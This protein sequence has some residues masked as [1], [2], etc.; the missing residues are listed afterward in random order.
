MSK[1]SGQKLKILYLLKFFKEK[2]DEEHGVTMSEI[3]AYLNSCG[4]TAERKS[5]YAD[6]EALNIFGADIAF[7]GRRYSLASRDFE[8]AELKLLADCVGASKFI[9]EKK[10]TELIKK[11]ENLASVYEAAEIR[12][13]VYI[14]DRVKA[15]NE[16][17]YYVIDTLHDAI[18]AGKKIRFMYYEYD[19]SKHRKAKHGGEPYVVS[20]Y[21][22]TVSDENY[23][24]IAHYPKYEKLTHFRVDRMEGVEI[25]DEQRTDI[26]TVAGDKFSLGEYSRSTFNMFKG[27]LETVKLR[28]DKSVITAVLDRFGSD[29]TVIPYDDGTFTAN[30]TVNVS[31]TFF[32]WVFTFGGMIKIEAPDSAS[33]KF[34]ELLG[35]FG[36]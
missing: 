7:D 16:K 35:K 23:Y 12:R 31:P 3:L 29:I 8:L 1:S 28:C 19:I 22:L 5:V 17:I 2:T 10:S 34:N 20:P 11:I 21:S 9:T 14:S 15:K 30:V 24:L 18:S 32:S 26:K 6:I 36:L 25:T 33:Q 27:E 4:I 13:Q